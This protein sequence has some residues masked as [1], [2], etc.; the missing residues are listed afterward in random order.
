MESR[1]RARDGLPSHTIA[2]PG[3]K[4]G[5]CRRYWE[6]GCGCDLLAV[7]DAITGPHIRRNEISTS[8]SRGR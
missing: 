1:I 7:P 2:N 3:A 8:Q 4:P 6:P 5:I